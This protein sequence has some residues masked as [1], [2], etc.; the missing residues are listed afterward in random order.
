MFHV[1][2][3]VVCVDADEPRRLIG[4]WDAE[5]VKGAVYTVTRVG[6]IHPNDPDSLPCILVAEIERLQC[7]PLWAHRFR[8]LEK[9]Q[10]DI[11][12]FTAMLTPKNEEIEA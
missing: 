10:T 8:P 11:S 12:I 3:K 9:S 7:E 6:L 1:G 4:V 5:L 2:Q